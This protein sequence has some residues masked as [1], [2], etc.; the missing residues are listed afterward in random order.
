M[1]TGY[2]ISLKL[3]IHRSV[4]VW[5]LQARPSSI[6]RHR[7]VIKV[8]FLHDCLLKY[9]GGYA[10]PGLRSVVR[11]LHRYGISGFKGT[12]AVHLPN[13][14]NYVERKGCFPGLGS[15]EDPALDVVEQLQRWMLLLR[16][17]L[18]SECEKKQP[19]E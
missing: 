17:A 14:K 15:S 13:R 16:L 12:C 7:G 19:A 2:P 18:H 6:A 1:V 9:V 5:L 3:L 8:T 4:F 10:Y 11:S